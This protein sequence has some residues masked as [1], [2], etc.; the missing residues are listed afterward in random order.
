MDVSGAGGKAKKGAAGRK[1][2]GP[3]KKSV[4]RSSRAGPACSW[5]QPDATISAKLSPCCMDALGTHA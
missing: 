3:T 1:A 4:S 5:S 2:G